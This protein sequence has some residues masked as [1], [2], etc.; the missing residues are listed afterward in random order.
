[1][2]PS[3]VA[4]GA[5]RSGGRGPP[6]RSTTPT[7]SSRSSMPIRWG[8]RSRARSTRSPPTGPSSWPAR[9]G[10]TSLSAPSESHRHGRP[11][12]FSARVSAGRSSCRPST[13]CDG[14][15]SWP[16]PGSSSSPEH[17]P[18]RRD[19]GRDR[20]GAGQTLAQGRAGPGSSI[21]ATG[22]SC[23]D[24]APRSPRLWS[25]S[26]RRLDRGG[27][28]PNPGPEAGPA[29]RQPAGR[30]RA[31]SAAVAGGNAR[32]DTSGSRARGDACGCRAR[33]DQGAPQEA[34][35]DQVCGP[36]RRGP[37]AE[38]G[39]SPRRRFPALVAPDPGR[40]RAGRRPGGLRP[41]KGGQ[42]VRPQSGRPWRTRPGPG[43]P[44]RAPNSPR[45]A[46]LRSLWSSRSSPPLR[47]PPLPCRSPPRPCRP[48]RRPRCH[49]AKKLSPVKKTAASKQAAVKKAAPAKKAAV[50]KAP[51]KKAGVKKAPA[52]KAAAAKKAAPP[53]GAG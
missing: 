43:R 46:P 13:R 33:A 15:S 32:G 5:A 28:R 47:S 25:P 29:S 38:P 41:R 35:G 39:R 42:E 18:R 37:T 11:G 6:S 24:S 45:R 34:G 10:V 7:C 8:P 16:S 53:G 51:A 44:P 1:M 3:T 27:R 22:P 4:S 23:S 40:G 2:R 31:G 26:R 52:K 12:T 21:C 30:D 50:K 48:L 19:R 9:R 49:P 36:G 14:G 20:V 17:R